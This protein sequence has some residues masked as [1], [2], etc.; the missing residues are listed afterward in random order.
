[1]SENSSPLSPVAPPSYSWKIRRRVMFSMLTFCMAT[2]GYILW[3]EMDTKVADTA[4]VMS[5]VIMGTILSTYVLA[6]TAE[7]VKRGNLFKDVT[8]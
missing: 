5:F 7:D 6:A 1:M 4:V 2:I 3:R 8:K